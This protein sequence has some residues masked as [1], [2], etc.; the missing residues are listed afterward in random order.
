MALTQAGLA[1]VLG[2]S[3]W[4]SAPTHASLLLPWWALAVGFTA[5]E[6]FVFHVQFQREAHTVSMSELPLVLGL[7]FAQPLQLLVGRLI[8]SAV[9]CLFHRRSSLLK[10]TWN[11]AFVGLQTAVSV[12][13]FVLCFVV[14]I[15][16]F[17]VNKL[18][19][20]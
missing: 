18:R 20:A 13:L 8:G 12:V 17:R 5:T 3:L 15:V 16:Q 9:I 6:A 1:A 19:S 11:L 10:T 4:G 2:W 7:F 14:T